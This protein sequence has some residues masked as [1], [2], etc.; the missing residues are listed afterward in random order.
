[1]FNNAS[2]YKWYGNKKVYELHLQWRNQQI[3]PC[4]FIYYSNLIAAV[5]CHLDTWVYY[6]VHAEIVPITEVNNYILFQQK[7][8]PYIVH[9]MNDNQSIINQNKIYNTPTIVLLWSTSA[10][11]R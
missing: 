6:E 11:F 2:N 5:N 9:D 3:V 10:R 4:D 7:Q 1:M 8:R